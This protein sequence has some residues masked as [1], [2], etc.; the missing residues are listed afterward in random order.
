VHVIVGIG[1]PGSRY[2]NNRHNVGFQ[3]LDYFADRKKLAFKASKFD[4]YYSEAE[5]SGNPF[6]LIKPVTYVNLS[7]VAV[8]NYINNF[9]INVKDLLIVLD[10]VNLQ[11]ASI[12]IRRSGGD[13]G[14]NGLKSIIYHLNSNQF[15]R[16]R[17]GVGNDFKIGQLSD[18]VLTDF[19]E[20]ELL[21][22]SKSFDLS[23]QLIENFVTDGYDKMLNTFSRFMKTENLKNNLE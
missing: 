18:Y 20:N 2:K 5:T 8:L 21:K 9:N 4:Y 10:D 1:N 11:T 16:L 7:G 19:S 13:G 22:L 6:V 14:H 3:F 23:I 15:P 12:R 17:I